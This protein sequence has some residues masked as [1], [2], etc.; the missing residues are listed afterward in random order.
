M[1]DALK[2][3]LEALEQTPPP[4]VWNNISRRL[5]TEFS[6]FDSK[7]SRKLDKAEITPPA[8]AWQ[9]IAAAIENK[10]E[11]KGIVIPMLIR[12][13]AVAAVIAVLLIAASMYFFQPGKDEQLSTSAPLSSV[14]PPV[15]DS[16]STPAIE[17]P[18]QQEA[19]P[20]STR[21]IAYNTRPAKRTANRQKIKNEPEPY[22]YESMNDI[23]ETRV[24][25]PETVPAVQ[26]INV[27]APPIRDDNGNIIMDMDLISKPGQ[28]YITVTS[29]S[30]DQTKISNKFISCLRYLNNNVHPYD[31]DLNAIECT[32]KFDEW[33]NKLLSEGAFIPSGDNFFDIFELKEMIQD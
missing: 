20:Q 29:P 19:E 26:D 23:Q 25:T 3:K 13:T 10:K 30:G 8:G 22:F 32:T 9:N 28:Q 2:K 1:S 6:T 14:T 31:A 11:K 18:V 33:R 16:Q 12:K 15:T 7:L 27:S 4:A 17:P 21:K 24:P 5:D